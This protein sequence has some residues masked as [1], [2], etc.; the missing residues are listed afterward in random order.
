MRDMNNHSPV[1]LQISLA[2]TDLPHAIHI[3]PHQLRQLAGQVDEVLLILDLHRSR[4]RF[5]EGW[6]ER[7]PKLR[8]LIDE[9]RA[10][11]SN[12][13]LQEVDYSP[14]V[15]A[16]VGSMF[17]NRKSVPTKD[18]RG[19]PFYSY[20]FGLY[21]AKH[22]YVF[23]IDSDL[24][25]GGGS[26]TWVAEAIELLAQRSDI[27]ICSPLP[28]APTSDGQLK[29]QTAEREP[30][31][32]LA[33]KFSNFS[34]RLF[35]I[36]KQRFTS[37]IKQLPLKSPSGRNLLK[38]W[39]E[40]NPPYELPEILFTQAMKRHSMLRIDFLGQEPGLWSI[41]P[42][43]RSKLF[44]DKLPEIIEQIESGNIPEAQRGDY[45]VNDSLV[46]WTEVRIALQEKY[47]W[48]RLRN[49]VFQNSPFPRT[50]KKFS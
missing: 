41:H 40:K 4:G 8:Q 46:D 38:A 27:L 15:I 2:P 29:S 6:N 21:A 5:S 47:W 36:D 28:G 22:N 10:K 43:Y 19:G 39:I 17:F 18:C 42:P 45:D 30:L 33:Y 24:M 35:L 11:Y 7:L 31:N 20:F 3:L 14:E 44:Y 12:V 32:S 9:Y 49:K 25:F 1:T 26:S 37:K 13:Y 48:R 34:S 50:D 16:Q 23:H